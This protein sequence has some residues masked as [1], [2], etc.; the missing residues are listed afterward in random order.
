MEKFKKLGISELVLKSIKEQKFT[1]PTE[2]QEKSIPLVL[3]GKDVMAESA[4]GSGKTLV[5]AAGI[6]Q[7]SERGKGIQ[8][9]ILTPT[10]E[11]AE[12]V[13]KS[14]ELFSKYSPLS[15]VAVYGG[16]SIGP[17]IRAL[18]TADVVVGT[19]G[20][21]LD[22]LNR[23]TLE[24]SSINTV[25][26]DEA[27]R[28]LDMGFAAD[29]E[30]ILNECPVERQTMLFSATFSK[31]MIRIGK[32]HMDSP[33][34]ISAEPHVDP[35]KLTQVC[36]DVRGNMK[37]SLLVHLLKEEKS[38]RVMVFCNTQRNTDFVA[39]NLKSVGINALPMHGGFSQN[40]RGKTM[41]QFNS[42]AQKSYALVCTDVA[43]RGL[44]IKGVS[45]IYNFDFPR[46]ID[47]YVHRIG[48]T[49]RA[50][51]EGMAVSLIAENDA[52]NLKATIKKTKLKLTW[53]KVPEIERLRVKKVEQAPP[54]RYSRKFNFKQK[55]HKTGFRKYSR[56]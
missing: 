27:D 40:Q 37:F 47:N 6:I 11:L 43:S 39:N 20:R 56:R 3:E 14:F 25:V 22:H 24:L 54:T 38:H 48:R 45:H 44:D 13:A 35:K 10:R 9:L 34:R 49:A 18:K 46:E 31:D 4:T 32:K 33:V 51:K 23:N 53:K 28:M 17:Q 12:Q 55:N 29:V 30:K 15:I 8:A 5:F 52:D 2:I 21:I 16:L 42:K 26:L 36:Y 50:G 1:E 19:P 7:S 41:V